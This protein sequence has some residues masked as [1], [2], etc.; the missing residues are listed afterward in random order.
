MATGTYRDWRVFRF[1]IGRKRLLRS[2]VAGL[3]L[4]ALL[5]TDVRLSTRFILAWDLTALLYIAFDHVDDPLLDGRDCHDHAALYDEGDWVILALVIASAAAS[6]V[7]IAVELPA[8]EVAAA[9]AG[10]RHLSSP[11]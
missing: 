10:A 11:A 6:F 3:I 9:F 2:T 4:L 5:P 8:I 1:I 7:C